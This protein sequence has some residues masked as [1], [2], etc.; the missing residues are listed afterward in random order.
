MIPRP[1]YIEWL[2]RW[3]DKP[4][5]KAITG[6]RRCGKSSMLKLFQEHLLTNGVNDTNIIAINFESLDEEYPTEAKPLYDYVVRLLKD[7]M[8]YVFLDEVQHVKDFERAVDA[9]ALREDVDL[10]ITGSNAYM[11][12]S[13]LTTL[14]TG[15]YV[16][17]RMLPLSFSEFRSA[18]EPQA[19]VDSLFQRYINYGGMPYIV[20]LDDEESISDYLGG[21]FN[22]IVVKDI[23]QRYPRMNMRSFNRTAMF[24]ADNIGNI[25]SLTKIS[26][27]LAGN[28]EKVSVN[29]VGEYT[30][31]LL[32]NYLIFKAERYDI[33][34]REYLETLEKYYVGDLGLRFWLL[35]KT[36]QDIGRCLENI[37]YL[38]LLRR[39]RR[40]SIGKIGD[41]EVDFVAV[42]QS[43][44]HYFQVSQ[45]VMDPA[46][47]NRELS[48]LQSIRNDYPKT[49]LTLDRIGATDY[50]GVSQINIIDW[51]LD[52]SSGQMA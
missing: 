47:L 14:L 18:W 25:S 4:L 23:A 10:Y 9:L 52:E 36:R 11:L 26:H 20:G 15:R 16:E 30:D 31:A 44:P 12:S 2:E 21:V 32:E 46:T 27:G 42:N 49:L 38:E 40:V 5:I 19:D 35:G 3:Q 43:G 45:T 39:F 22:T 33:K 50:D 24:L 1:Q 41:K 13:E 6:L 51:L 37:V 48:A 8:N 34:G 29:A 7:G 17:L 28:N